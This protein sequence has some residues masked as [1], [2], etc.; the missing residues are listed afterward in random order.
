MMKKLCKGALVML[1]LLGSSLAQ[2]VQATWQQV[3]YN[4][5]GVAGPSAIFRNINQSSHWLTYCTSGASAVSVWLEASGN[6]TTGWV[7]ISNVGTSATAACGTIQA[8]GYYANVRANFTITGGTITAFYSASTG[9]TATPSNAGISI[10]DQPVTFVP[11][12]D[13]TGVTTATALKSTSFSLGSALGVLFGGSVYNPNAS[14]VYVAF[15]SS[16]TPFSGG[17]SGTYIVGVAAGA[18]LNLLVPTVGIAFTGAPIHMACS[19]SP[20][21]ASDPASACVVT[22]LWKPVPGA[23]TVATVPN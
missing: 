10:T 7:T 17:G 12:L 15:S 8:G 18:T 14:A 6:G 4:A 21:S 5:V 2:T 23:I 20:T 3:A 11:V 13:G 19:T 16:S 22:A 1:A 9:T